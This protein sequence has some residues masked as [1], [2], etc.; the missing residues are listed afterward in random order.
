MSQNSYNPMST[1]RPD[2][3]DFAD[4]FLN[5]RPLID[6][7]AP[8]EFAKGAF[9]NAVSLPL[10]TDQER[11]KVGTCYKK[12]GQD[13]A[14]KLGHQ[15]VKGETKQSRVNAWAAFTRKHPEGFIYCFRGGL[16][17]QISQQWLAESGHPYP[18][19]IGGY[20]AMRRYLLDHLEATTPLTPMVILGGRTGCA[21]TH[22]LKQ[23]PDQI[24]LEGLAH[25][26]GSAFGKRLGGQPAQIGF[27]N[28]FSINLL[29]YRHH[30]RAHV[31]IPPLVLE[32]ESHLIGRC[33]LPPVLQQQMQQ[34]P[35]VLLELPLDQ[36]IE[37]S[38]HDYILSNLTESQQALGEEQG[39][40][41]FAEGLRKA[42]SKLKRRLGDLRYR[43]MLALLED[44]LSRH[45]RGEPEAH[46]QWISPLLV[47]YY[48]PMYDY[49]LTKKA[50]RIVYRGG[51][52]EISELLQNSEQRQQ[53]LHQL[54]SNHQTKG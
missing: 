21:K 20:K 27:E 36:R 30:Y 11:A 48:D 42:M 37:H 12:H 16:R 49:Q 29:K 45:L 33:A 54:K 13:A 8:L 10:M 22:L 32:D 34:S 39:F 3:Q 18:R 46:K 9:P 53:L 14:I 41:S 38:Y 4:I 24:D 43:E 2:S 52:E 15:L 35:L 5:D 6:T 26:R 44:A 51:P 23:L 31:S 40:D 47:E 1:K 25:H 19:I 50:Q 28:A 7:R 17:S